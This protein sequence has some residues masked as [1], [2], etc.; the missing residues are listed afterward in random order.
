MADPHAKLRAQIRAGRE[1]L[2]MTQKDLSQHLGVSFA[3]IS[4]AEIG[5]TKSGDV[6]LEIKRALERLGIVFTKN[7]VELAHDYVDILEGEDCYLRL[8]DEISSAL[9]ESEDKEL[10][11]MFSSDQV[12]P[13]EVNARY[14]QLRKNGVKMRQLI[15]KGDTHIMGPLKEYRTIPEKYFTNIVTVIYGKNVA[16]VSGDEMRIIIHHDARLAERERKIFGY[17]WDTGAK[18]TYSKAE[19]RF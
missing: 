3:K 4:K 5:D 9:S 18:P 15:K 16:Q 14:R 13:Q 19:E 8:L 2:G 1:L 12:S 11:I 17:F 6:L 10:L 7:G